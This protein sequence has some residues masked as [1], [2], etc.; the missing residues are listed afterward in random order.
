M[1]SSL[2]R[3]NP[4][5]F[6]ALGPIVVPINQEFCRDFLSQVTCSQSLC[7]VDY[8]PEKAGVGGSIP[9]LATISTNTLLYSAALRG[10][11]L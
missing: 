9:S 5:A 10:E 3:R 1:G 7:M 8:S 2:L 11:R 6:V 4:H